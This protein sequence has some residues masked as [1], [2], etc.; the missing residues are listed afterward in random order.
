MEINTVKGDLKRDA[1]VKKTGRKDLFLVHLR[2]NR[3]HLSYN[4]LNQIAIQFI[5]VPNGPVDQYITDY[6][7][8]QAHQQHVLKI[9]CKHYRTKMV[10]IRKYIFTSDLYVKIQVFNM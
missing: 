6:R 7:V 5:K 9:N 4:N 1:F 8:K 2:K 10:K 3:F